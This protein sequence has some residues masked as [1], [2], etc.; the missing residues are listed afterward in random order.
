M[1]STRPAHG[2]SGP[3]TSPS[4]DGFGPHGRVEIFATR[5]RPEIKAEGLLSAQGGVKVYS[6]CDLDFSK[7]DILQVEDVKNV[8]VN[9]GKDRL[10]SGIATGAIHVI[11][12]MAIGDRG[13][14]PTDPTVWKTVDATMTGL[15]NEVYRADTELVVLGIGTADKHEVKFIKTFSAVDVPLTAFSNPGAP[16]INEVGLITADLTTGSPLPRL[17]VSSPNAPDADEA[18]FAVRTYKSVPFE[19]AN[20]IS[21]TVRYTIYV[22]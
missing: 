1:P 12:R 19:A 9:A 20:D 11:C 4:K 17:P 18:L 10:I 13:A 7:C 16:V 3:L 15:Y 6:T 22:E 2:L 14:M 21:V 5:G 8:I